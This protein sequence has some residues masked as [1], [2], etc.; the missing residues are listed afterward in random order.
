L[1]NS[2]EKARDSSRIWDLKNIQMGLEQYYAEY[3]EYPT[4]IN[5]NKELEMYLYGKPKDP[6]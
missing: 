6:L 3:S 1:L 5:D 2:K 4:T